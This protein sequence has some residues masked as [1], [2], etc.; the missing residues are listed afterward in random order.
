MDIR[1]EIFSGAIADAVNRALQYEIID[2]DDA[3]TSVALTVLNEI[4]CIIRDDTIKD[5][6]EVVEEIV[7]VF[8]KYNI[9]AGFRH[10]F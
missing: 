3:I 6:F 10:D 8:E 9:S 2:M 5:D 7:R 4:Q 1:L